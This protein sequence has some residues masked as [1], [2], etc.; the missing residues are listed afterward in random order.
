MTLDEAIKH[1]Q[2][3][4]EENQAIVDAC[5]Y[6]GDNMAECETC[7]DE[8]RQLAEWLKELKKFKERQPY[9]KFENVKDHIYKL[10]GDYKCWDNRLTEDEAVELCHILEQQPSEDCV[11]LAEVFEIMGNLMS[12]PYD[13]DRPINE[14]DVSKSMDK[15]KALPP[16]TPTFPSSEDCVSRQAVID[17]TGL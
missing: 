14:D 7:A 13:F 15:I 2:E 11:S 6:Y 17:M 10:A 9:E 16:V 5:D 1:C 4:A 3:V 8:H 12:I